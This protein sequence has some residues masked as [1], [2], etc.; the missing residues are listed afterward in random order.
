MRSSTTE[1][2]APPGTLCAFSP[3]ACYKLLQGTAGSIGESSGID[4]L[5]D[6]PGFR[7]VRHRQKVSPKCPEAAFSGVRL[8]GD[9]GSSQHLAVPDQQ[10]R[11]PIGGCISLAYRRKLLSAVEGYPTQLE[12]QRG[13][14]ESMRFMISARMPTQKAN[15]A[16]KGGGFPQTL[17]SVMEELQPEA[18]YFTDVDGARGGYFIVNMDDASELPAKAEPLYFALGAE[19]EVHLVMTPEDLQ[20][21]TPALEQAAQKYG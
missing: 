13:V 20:K 12:R 14:R 7:R 6:V 18:A 5:T 3:L 9:L 11:Y 17:Q 4:R 16:I 10:Q 19:I 1:Y 8:N 21:A 2:P 15:A